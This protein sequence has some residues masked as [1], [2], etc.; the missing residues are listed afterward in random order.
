M[1]GDC[2]KPA[3]H[4]GLVDRLARLADRMGERCLGQSGNR[5]ERCSAEAGKDGGSHEQFG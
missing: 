4:G 3:E 1:G 5:R 2:R